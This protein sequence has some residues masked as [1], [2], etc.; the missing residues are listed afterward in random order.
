MGVKSKRGPS[1]SVDPGF[2]PRLRKAMTAAGL[3][4]WQLVDK[5]PVSLYALTN[6]LSG[7]VNPSYPTL[8]AICKATGADANYLLGLK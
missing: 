6:I 5:M 1:H 2:A 8:V 4:T 7:N 3:D